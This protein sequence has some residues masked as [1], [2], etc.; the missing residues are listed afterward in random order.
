MEK[1]IIKER[2]GSIDIRHKI[3]P[4]ELIDKINKKIESA[5]QKGYSNISIIPYDD[6]AEYQDDHSDRGLAFYGERLETDREIELRKNEVNYANFRQYE[7]FILLKNKFESEE[8]KKLV[9]E[10]E[11]K[12]KR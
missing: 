8:G 10:Y 7:N 3:S 11:S 12:N 5:K 9:E 2:F 4:N 1:K 6:P